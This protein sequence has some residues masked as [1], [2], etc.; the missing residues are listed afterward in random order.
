M[1]IRSVLMKMVIY[2]T[3]SIKNAISICAD[4]ESVVTLGL[5]QIKKENNIVVATADFESVVMLVLAQDSVVAPVDFES[6]VALVLA[7]VKKENDAVVAPVDFESVCGC[8]RRF[9]KRCN[10]G[11]DPD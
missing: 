9:R 8:S 3:T 7:Q 1:K 5:A 6:V 2:D 10:N 4:F 11:V